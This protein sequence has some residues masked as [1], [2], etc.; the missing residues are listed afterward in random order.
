MGSTIKTFCEQLAELDVGQYLKSGAFGE[1]DLEL[2][3][4][5]LSDLIEGEELTEALPFIF[6][7]YEKHPNIELGNP[8]PLANLIE[9][10]TTDYIPA[11]LT[12]IESKPTYVT[13]NLLARVLNSNIADA[14]KTRFMS[15]IENVARSESVDKY[16]RATAKEY[17]EHKA[18][19]WGT[20]QAN[21]G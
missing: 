1:S 20:A 10:S 14:E 2:A 12:S 21:I 18:L 3:L 7:F 9:G 19:A 13:V 16:A 15:I 6:K 11:L 4:Y 17:M 5:D 8:G